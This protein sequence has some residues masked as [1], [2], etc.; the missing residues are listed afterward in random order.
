MPS[1]DFNASA[2]TTEKHIPA[3]ATRLKKAFDYYEHTVQEFLP[4]RTRSEGLKECLIHAAVVHAF[5]DDEYKLFPEFPLPVM[6]D[7]TG[8]QKNG[9]SLDLLI[10]NKSEKFCVLCEWKR[11]DCTDDLHCDI[12]DQVE[13]MKQITTISLFSGIDADARLEYKKQDKFAQYGD[14]K[15]YC[16]WVF[17]DPAENAKEWL[18]ENKKVRELGNPFKDWTRCEIQSGL[19]PVWLYAVCNQEMLQK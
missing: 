16:L 6:N 8:K 11:L 15:I 1:L 5:G 2:M 14:Y 19:V 18:L 13:R 10:I 3:L 9:G 17:I 7:K 4:R 12:N